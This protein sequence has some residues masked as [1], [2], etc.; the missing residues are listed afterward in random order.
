MAVLSSAADVRKAFPHGFPP[1]DFLAAVARAGHTLSPELAKQ[2]NDAL[3][4]IRSRYPAAKRRQWASTADASVFHVRTADA[5]ITAVAR[6]APGDYDVIASVD[7][8]TVDKILNGLLFSRT[9]P[10]KVAIGSILSAAEL[11]NFTT[12]VLR[13]TFNGVPDGVNVSA[14]NLRIGPTVQTTPVPGTNQLRLHIPF[15]VEIVDVMISPIG[16]IRRTVLTELRGMAAI[17]VAAAAKVSVSQSHL[18]VTVSLP[19]TSE[20]ADPL[21]ID[22]AADSP[23][24]PKSA[25]QLDSFTTVLGL[26][27]NRFLSPVLPTLQISPFI[28]LPKFNRT[29]VLIRQI[30]LR[31]QAGPNGGAIVIGS[32]IGGPSPDPGDPTR[33]TNPFSANPG[34]LFLRIHEQLLQ[35]V[36][37]DLIQSGELDQLAKD[38]SGYD[39]VHIKSAS[40]SISDNTITIDLNGNLQNACAH[41]IDAPF[42]TTLTVKFSFPDANKIVID[43]DA[44]TGPDWSSG[45]T[46]VCIIA[47]LA[48]G[49][50]AFFLGSFL[51]GGV[52]LGVLSGFLDFFLA[53]QFGRIVGQEIWDK[54][55]S[56]FSSSSG[57]GPKE[58]IVPLNFPVPGTELLPRLTVAGLRAQGGAQEEWFSLTFAPDDINYHVYAAFFKEGNFPA[59][60]IT[61]VSGGP[62]TLMDQDV[63]QPAG[64]DIQIPD[65]GERVITNPKFITTITV[66][67]DPPMANE[68]LGR[69]TTT[70]EGIAHITVP[71]EKWH[72]N[73][74]FRVVTRTIEPVH[75]GP[76]KTTVRRTPL[77]ERAPDLYFL[78]TLIPGN[79]IDTRSL[80][81]SL[82]LNSDPATK[83]VGSPGGPIGFTIKDQVVIH[84]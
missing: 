48:E 7:L 62:V 70:L 58:V 69:A 44:S 30:D 9:L 28:A 59:R 32:R 37:D 20:P 14:G 75:D 50:L 77:G 67:Y 83:R 10:N 78:L 34:N 4:S 79:P 45:W 22:I 27:L 81:Q 3:A 38:Q 47:S 2:F 55:T 39:D 49:V 31:T 56:I 29:R 80:T 65:L 74:G 46:Y 12:N 18:S 72:N 24:Q 26:V 76:I 1:G 17:S 40:V 6:R 84:P 13:G 57:G 60:I 63:P 71:P 66:S 36:I 52:I 43:F 41:V 42:T 51:L 23:V 73:G 16:R 61:T 25:Q 33:L 21:H 53:Q 8:S 19:P 35:T 68:N 54:V 5:P 64:D 82:L 15:A 11:T